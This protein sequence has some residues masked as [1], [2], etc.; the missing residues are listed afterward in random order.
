MWLHCAKISPEN[1]L[2]NDCDLYLETEIKSY[3]RNRLSHAVRFWDYESFKFSN[4][5]FLR[6]FIRLISF[7][8]AMKYVLVLSKFDTNIFISFFQVRMMDQLFIRNQFIRHFVNKINRKWYFVTKIVLTYLFDTINL[9]GYF[10]LHKCLS[11][12]QVKK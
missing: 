4:C 10:D 2:A 3:N 6:I 5:I 11:I 1:V 7:A 12:F 9:R 8:F